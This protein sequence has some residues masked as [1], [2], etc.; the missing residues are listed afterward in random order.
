MNF[1]KDFPEIIKN[2]KHSSFEGL[3]EQEIF[4]KVNFSDK[5]LR[6]VRKDILAQLLFSEIKN[7]LSGEKIKQYDFQRYR[8]FFIF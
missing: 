8:D 3:N 2:K 1:I 5:T 7:T 6:P 4:N